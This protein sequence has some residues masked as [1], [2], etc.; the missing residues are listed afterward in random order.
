M[1]GKY[2][3]EKRIRNSLE[4]EDSVMTATRKEEAFL[5][6]PFKKRGLS[7]LWYS[8][9]FIILV[10][11]IRVF[12]LDVVKGSHYE[13]VSRGNRIRSV[14]IKA[15]RGNIK[16]KY[17]KVLARNVPSIDAIV[18]P[19]DLPAGSEEKKVV[20][21]KVAEI[22]NMEAGN[23]ELILESQDKKSLEP[24]LLKEN[25]SQDQSLIISE[26]LSELPGIN[27]EK[28]AIRSY[29]NS[30]IFAHLVG[31]D[32]KITREELAKNEGYLM[33]DYIGKSGLE[34]NYEKEL[35]GIYGKRQVEIDSVGNI[36]KNLGVINPQPG[37]DLILSIDEAL[38]KK[39][40]DSLSAVLE[41]T[42]T[43]TAAAVA[44]DPR[45]G[46]VLAMV[47]LPSFDN[48][49]FAR[50]ISNDEY[51]AIMADKNLPLFNRAVSGEY[52][53]GST[54]KPA[55]ACAALSEGTISSSTII[56]G[57]GGVLRIGSF[58]FGDWK[59]HGPSDVRSAIAESN[60]IFFYTI[61]GGYGNISGLGMD[62]MKKYNALFGFGRP[63]GIDLP[64]ESPGFIPDENWKL[65]R[66]G[67]KWYIGNSYHAAIGQGYITAT[68]LQ[69]ANYTA[70]IA[71]GGTLYSPKIG[72]RIKRGDGSESIISPEIIDKGFISKEVLGIVREGM[73]QAVT[74]GT[75][76]TLKDLPIEAAGKT[77]TAQ[78]GSEDKTHAWFVSFA[79]YDNPTIAMVV[80]A[81]GGGEG[82]SSAVPVTKEVYEWYF[83]QNR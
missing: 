74:D 76:Q 56:G 20:A 29:E 31:Y 21:G 5:E 71:N 34:K 17:G 58:S 53:P 27:L 48:N 22:L 45:N 82:H 68:P 13:E 9:V 38:Q 79:P 55:V 67:E 51:K 8:I 15:P 78:F 80:L 10:L 72:N 42:E 3:R 30:F 59:V 24:V 25:V 73:R 7:F 37:N 44:I 60:D 77:G 2:L 49:N 50:G 54:L 40:Y 18:V 65:E 36:K 43:A 33:T 83:N 28:T 47:S 32:G 69:L 81:E 39:I 23:V 14:I 62:R 6:A 57:L 4:I 19:T 46:G 52:P 1:L 61:G 12:Y 41:K 26:K 35:R 64:G 66:L 75:A 11:T 63:T 16:D 70:A